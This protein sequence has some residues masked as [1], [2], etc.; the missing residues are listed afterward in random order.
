MTSTIRSEPARIS[1]KSPRLRV[2]TP[3]ISGRIPVSACTWDARSASNWA[4][5]PPTVPCPSRPMRNGSADIAGEQVLVG[6]AAHHDARAAVAHEHD[7]RARDA[8][9]GVVHR[10]TV[11]AGRRRDDDVAGPRVG[12]LDV[13]SDDVAGLAVLAGQVAA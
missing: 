7:R 2:S 10:E 13:I 8:V 9:V 12:Q 3:L 11:R 6:L 1:S 5:A 4:N